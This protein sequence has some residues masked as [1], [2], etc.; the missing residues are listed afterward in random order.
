MGFNDQYSI[1][2]DCTYTMNS[3]DYIDYGLMKEFFGRIKVIVSTKTYTIDDLKKILIESEISP[4]KGFE[5]N[6]IM[7]GYSGI[8]YNDEIIDRLATE[9]YDMGTGARALQ[10]LVTGMQDVILYDLITKEYDLDSPVP[11]SMKLLD[12]YKQ[13]T[14]RRY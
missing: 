14:I 3:D 13:R 5:K 1:N 6:S 10:S 9:A 4:I 12:N 2:N 8:E 7:L 11:L